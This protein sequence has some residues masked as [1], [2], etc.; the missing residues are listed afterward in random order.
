VCD[1]PWGAHND[2][3]LY[4]VLK[5]ECDSILQDESFKPN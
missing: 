1:C 2:Y 5:I 4:L 3:A